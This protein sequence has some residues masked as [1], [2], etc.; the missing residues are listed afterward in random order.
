MVEVEVLS[1]EFPPAVLAY[2]VIPGINIKPAKP[3][4]ALRDSIIT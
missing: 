3:Y 2:V 4:L 1:G